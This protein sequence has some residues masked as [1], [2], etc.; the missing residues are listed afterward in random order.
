MRKRSKLEKF[1]EDV[2]KMYTLEYKSATQIA[3]KYS[4]TVTTVTSFLKSKGVDIRKKSE[5]ISMAWDRRKEDTITF[6]AYIENLS[7]RLSG[8]T[9]STESR[10]KMSNT[11][12]KKIA[13]GEIRH[14]TYGKSEHY[15]GFFVRSSYEKKFVDLCEEWKI[16]IEP[17]RYIIPYIGKD[18]K[19]HNYIPD[20]YDHTKARIFEIK[21][22][23]L[24]QTKTNQL[25]FKAARKF[26]KER[27]I[28]FHIITEITLFKQPIFREDYE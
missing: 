28:T 20:F 14:R 6:A 24:T 17:C 10:K 27:G 25:K 12:S 7:K 4:C 5:S 16:G 18:G 15:K 3:R 8:R 26:C 23:K 11:R 2:V 19:Y 1:Q 21:P 22:A 9:F 13:S